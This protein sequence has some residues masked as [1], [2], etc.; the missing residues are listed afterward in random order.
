MAQDRPESA[1]KDKHYDLV[2]VLYGSLKTV[3]KLETY[4]A[5]ARREGDDELAQF[6]EKLQEKSREVGDEAKRLLA[7]RLKKEET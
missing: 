3:W 5:D 2:T 6:F 7:D 4:K 1:A